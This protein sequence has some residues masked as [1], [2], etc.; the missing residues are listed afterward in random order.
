MME[1]RGYQFKIIP[2]SQQIEVFSKTFGCVRFVYNK[3]LEKKIKHY[4]QT[5]KSIQVTPAS[6]KEEYPFLKEVDSLALANTQLH[7]ESECKKFFKEKNVGFPKWKCKYDSKNSYTTNFVNGNMKLY[8]DVT[9]RCTYIKLP[10]V[11]AIC[12]QLHRLSHGT[13]K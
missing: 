6:F 2:T 5:K 13:L 4:E 8:S 10:K 9:N 12:I 11:G 7:L 1:R 3:M